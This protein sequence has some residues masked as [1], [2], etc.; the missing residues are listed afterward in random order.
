MIIDSPV[1]PII[2]F[3]SNNEFTLE[4]MGIPLLKSF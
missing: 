1:P 4:T 3:S 2:W